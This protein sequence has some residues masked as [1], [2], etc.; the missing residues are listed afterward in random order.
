[1][2][3]KSITTS[4]LLQSSAIV[5]GGSLAASILQYL[6][7]IVMA[8]LLSPESFGSLA[9]LLSWITILVFPAGVISMHVARQ[10]AI[11]LA[12]DEKLRLI[13]LYRRNNLISLAGIAS[14]ITAILFAKSFKF[15]PAAWPFSYFLLTVII[16]GFAL[17]S[18]VND[19]LLHGSQYFIRLSLL[20]FIGALFKFFLS[21]ILVANGYEV[22]G[23]AIALA[24]SGAITYIFSF[25]LARRVLHSIV[26]RPSEQIEV[27]P[28]TNV[29]YI[30]YIFAALFLLLL[31][32]NIDVILAK[33]WLEA[34]AAGYYAILA[35]A[36]KVIVF[37][38][39][40]ISG[41]A[42]PSAAQTAATGSGQEKR[43]LK[44]SLSTVMA[45]DIVAVIFYIFWPKQ[46]ITIVFG[47]GYLPAAAH[48]GHI[49]IIAGLWA[50]IQLYTRLLLA[51]GNRVFLIPL[52]LLIA[53]EVAGIS[54]W[55]QSISVILLIL[56]ITG[57]LLVLSLSI[58]YQR[59][60][61]SIQ[62]TSPIRYRS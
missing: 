24:A 8:R 42:F 55:H 38:T 33:H 51:K 50:I 20:A 16:I 46:I 6:F 29:H 40:S 44:T 12:Q 53:A 19:G 22:F 54:I 47:T 39:M 25:W 28:S 57:S 21:G 41:V 49:G 43:I 56:F 48:L 26:V 30:P 17:L 37:G 11:Y 62:I 52:A 3:Q 13:K 32:S 18:A 45:I 61:Y 59:S 34:D 10:T 4:Y 35:T 9:S 60:L 58:I 36:G 15:F 23:V 7:T 14:V 27:L 1:M 2:S 31:L 5:L